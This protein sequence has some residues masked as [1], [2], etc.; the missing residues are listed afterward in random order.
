M[1]VTA[2][3]NVSKFN[4]RG[5]A[6]SGSALASEARGRGF[7]SR[8]PDHLTLLKT[9]ACLL[10]LLV[11]S[12]S[13]NSQTPTTYTVR[14]GD[15]LMSIAQRFGAPL[16]EITTKNKLDTS[17]IH[18]GQELKIPQA[19][20]QLNSEDIRFARPCKKHG[21]V[22]NSFG[23]YKEEGLLLP[24]TGIEFIVPSKTKLTSCAHGV[25]RH[26]GF[27]SGLG[28]L[29]IIDH[30]GGYHTALSPFAKST[31]KVSVGD[32]VVQGQTLGTV[33]T[34]PKGKTTSVHLELRKDTLA[35]DPSRLLE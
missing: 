28:M 11:T 5:V 30:G 14:T 35:V 13:A 2:Q 25:V 24:H 4:G 29:I 18:A 3:N 32:A 1:A 15:Y 27:I 21:K 19:L 34:A 10:L 33:A 7:K 17:I 6:Q 20:S 12:T 22:L 8:R 16:N 23:A 9:T 31:I 26:V